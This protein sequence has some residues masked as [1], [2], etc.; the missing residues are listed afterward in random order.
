MTGKRLLLLCVMTAGGFI[1]ATAAPSKWPWR[2]EKCRLLPH[3]KL[4]GDRAT[5]PFT[6]TFDVDPKR[7][8]QK[9]IRVSCNC[10]DSP[11]SDSGDF[12]CTEAQILIPVLFSDTSEGELVSGTRNDG[13]FNPGMR[14]DMLL[15]SYACVCSTRRSVMALPDGV[16]RPVVVP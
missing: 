2:D 5:C 8:P 9:I 11:C 16:S 12:R 3:S 4:I 6:T 7:C 1:L 13:V 15:V 14:V 10:S